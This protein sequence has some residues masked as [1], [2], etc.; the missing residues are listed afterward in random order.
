MGR[1][2][3]RGASMQTLCLIAQLNQRFLIAPLRTAARTS[4]RSQVRITQL[5]KVGILS[6]RSVT[7]LIRTAILSISCVAKLTEAG[8]L[9]LWGII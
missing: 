2:V 9:M 5:G 7:K 4:D 1:F 8:I 3:S 6:I